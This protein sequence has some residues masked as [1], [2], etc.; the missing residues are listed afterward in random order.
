[1]LHNIQ[2]DN[3]DVQVINVDAVDDLKVEVVNIDVVYII[4]WFPL[5]HVFN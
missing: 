1:M 5:T 2:V 4:G 3:L